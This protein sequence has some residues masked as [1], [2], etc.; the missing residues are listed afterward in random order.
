[1]SVLVDKRRSEQYGY[2]QLAQNFKNNLYLRHAHPQ[3]DGYGSYHGEFV[4][5]R[6]P[7]LWPFFKFYRRQ[8]LVAR[9]FLSEEVLSGARVQYTV[10]KAHFS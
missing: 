2:S 10:D 4:V 6:A 1:M 5:G 7:E 8:P 9:D 3:M